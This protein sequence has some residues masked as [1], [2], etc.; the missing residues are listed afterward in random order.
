M[1][2]FV[3]LA[4]A[5]T[6]STPAIADTTMFS[7]DPDLSNGAGPV[8]HAG[9]NSNGDVR[10][11]MLRFD[12]SGIPAG[13]VVTDVTVRLVV[14][15]AGGP[16][17]PTDLSLH[18]VVRGWDQAGSSTGS[19]SG[20]PAQLGDA[21]WGWAVWATE[22]WTTPGGDMGPASATT[23]VAGVGPY[24]WSGPGLVADLQAVV[25]G[26]PN[27]GWL[28]RV[29]DELTTQSAKRFPS[30][31]AA[32]DAPV[33]EVP[34][35]HGPLG[36]TPPGPGVAGVDNTVV[37]SAAAPGGNVVLVAGGAAG[38]VPVPDAPESA[39]GT[40]RTKV[41]SPPGSAATTPRICGLAT[42]SVTPGQPGT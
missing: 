40:R 11:A 13:A 16:G 2:F 6:L 26:G 3:G 36:L 18:P 25:D 32:L 41:A 38:A 9:T 21:T 22:P 10:R 19:G 39:A 27:H 33:L 28:L 17:L 4:R 29:D 14:D 15:Q 1:F 35:T 5:A 20:A 24:E 42:P 7:E 8:I 12:L 23:S 31:E 34:Y 37:A 30:S